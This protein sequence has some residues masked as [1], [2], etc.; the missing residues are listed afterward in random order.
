[1][2]CLVLIGTRAVLPFVKHGDTGHE[3]VRLT[4]LVPPCLC[5]VASRNHL[6]FGAHF[7]VE[8]WDGCFDVDSRLHMLCYLYVLQRKDRKPNA[9]REPRGLPRRLRA[10]VGWPRSD[11]VRVL[12]ARSMYSAF[13]ALPSL[14]SVRVCK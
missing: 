14:W 6:W 7:K 12:P 10:V 1:M 9:G 3:L 11:T 4:T 5:P 2:L 13:E 8:A